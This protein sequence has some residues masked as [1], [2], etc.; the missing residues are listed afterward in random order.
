[1][2]RRGT[3]ARSVVAVLL[4]ACAAQAQT[5]QELEGHRAAVSAVAFRPDGRRLATASYDHTVKVWDAAAGKV[6]HTFDGH[7]AHVLTLAWSPDGVRL[8]SGGLDGLRLWD[9]ATGKA[10]P[11]PEGREK[12]VQCVVFTPDGRRL[13]SCGDSGSVEVWDAATGAL[14]ET[15]NPSPDPLYAVAV[16]PDGKRLAAGGFDRMIHIYDLQTGKEK[17]A[18]DGHGDAVYSVAFAPDGATLL[19]GSGD[20]TLRRWDLATGRQT[21]CIDGGGGAVYQVGFSP[22]GRR[23]VSAGLDGE[24]VVWDAETGRPLHSRRFPS[25]TLCA[26]LRPGRQARRGRR[27]PG[28]LLL[29]GASKAHSIGPSLPARHVEERAAV[30]EQAVA[31]GAGPEDAHP[32]VVGWFAVGARDEDV[33]LVAEQPPRADEPDARRGQIP[34]EKSEFLAAFRADGDGLHEVHAVLAAALDRRVAA[35]RI[36]AEELSDGSLNVLL[37]GLLPADA[38][39][40]GGAVVVATAAEVQR[41]PG[42]GDD[43]L[44]QFIGR[45]GLRQ[46]L[47][48]LA[49]DDIALAL[50]PADDLV[51][52]ALQVGPGHVECLSGGGRMLSQE[53]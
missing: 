21:A 11:V 45:P 19:S 47:A 1:M 12:C 51:R 24:V 5:V 49:R 30:L 10:G 42:Q 39:A 50:R 4:S 2:D 48:H 14:L 13:V 7:R 17:W 41:L 36:V 26:R 15:L 8:A 6:V 28:R 23:L 27:G 29:D 18:L 25:K 37:L 32:E 44:P 22:D 35:R 38:V 16:S 31:D 40:D 3:T 33:D 43:V 52:D 20:Q 53:V 9:A 46:L 34:T